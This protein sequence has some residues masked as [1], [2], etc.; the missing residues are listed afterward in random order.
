MVA[1]A[2]TEGALDPRLAL[3][4]TIM[5]LVGLWLATVFQ[6]N[7]FLNTQVPSRPALGC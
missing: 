3:V 7:N 4:F 6:A 2:I 1:G 5:G